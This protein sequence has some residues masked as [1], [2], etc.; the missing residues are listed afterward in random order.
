MSGEIKP[1]YVD[2]EP[3]CSFDCKSN[4]DWRYCHVT[5]RGI[6]R[7]DPCIPALRWDRDKHAMRIGAEAEYLRVKLE[8]LIS[9]EEPIWEEDIRQILDSVDAC[10]SLRF[11]EQV[12]QSLISEK[13]DR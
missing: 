11:L 10:D 7:N 4:I 12:K 1:Q 5:K 13:D 9:E 2:I 6:N 3:M 8:R